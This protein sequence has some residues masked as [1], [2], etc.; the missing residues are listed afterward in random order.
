M[1]GFNLI[2]T[3]TTFFFNFAILLIKKSSLSDSTLINNIFFSIAYLSSASVLPTPEK[4]I[5]LGLIPDFNAFTNSPFETTS[6]PILNFLISLR[7]FLLELD[8][9]EKQ[10]NGFIPLKL[11]LKLI[12]FVL[13]SL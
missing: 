6:A 12:I 11:F 3:F 9:T 2:P 1:S 5:L 10:I 7:I 13:N 4:T 8:L